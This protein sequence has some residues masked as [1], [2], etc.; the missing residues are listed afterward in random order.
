MIAFYSGMLRD[1]FDPPEA[2]RRSQL[3]IMLNPRTA[4]PYYWAAF[5]ITSTI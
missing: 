5:A 3:Q 4:A 1:G 2:L